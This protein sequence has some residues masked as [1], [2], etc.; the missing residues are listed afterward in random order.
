MEGVVYCLIAANI[1]ERPHL[2]VGSPFVRMDGGLWC[3]MS[4]IGNRVAAR[5]FGTSSM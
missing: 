4:M 2:V 5:L 1:R 3:N